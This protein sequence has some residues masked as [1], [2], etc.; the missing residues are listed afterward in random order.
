MHKAALGNQEGLARLLAIAAEKMDLPKRKAPTFAK[1]TSPE[2]ALE[3]VKSTLIETQTTFAAA[4]A[5]LSK[6]EI[7]E[8]QT[9]LVPVLITQN[10][11]GHTLQDRGTGRRLCDLMEKM[12]R[13]SSARRPT[14]LP[15]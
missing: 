10:Q 8:L 2:Q 13:D 4:L 5:P 1:V 11:V 7:R 14:R 12:D 15:R 3:I 6:S 9:N